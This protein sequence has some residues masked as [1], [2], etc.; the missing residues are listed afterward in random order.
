[1]TSASLDEIEREVE[2]ARSRL[3]GDIAR[4]RNPDTIDNAKHE[5]MSRAVAY[6]D[7]ALGRVRDEANGRAH[8]ITEDIKQRI[9][10][11]PTA[12][13]LIGA[14]LAWH[15]M[16]HPPITTLLV[17]SGLF[18]LFRPDLVEQTRDQLTAQLSDKVNETSAVVQ[19]RAREWTGRVSDLADQAGARISDTAEPALV[20]ASNVDD[21][22]RQRVEENPLLY[23]LAAAAIGAAVGVTAKRRS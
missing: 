5:L 11:H 17:G 21:A 14:G 15:V 1:M 19:E 18:A 9:S 23:A 3:A 13:V 7:Q 22:M 16:R 10:D 2:R 4:L 8:S 6:K 20:A 12:A